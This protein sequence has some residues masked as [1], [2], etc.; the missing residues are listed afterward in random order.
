[1]ISR[2]E[3]SQIKQLWSLHAQYERW[4]FLENSWILHI[5]KASIAAGVFKKEDYSDI[6]HDNRWVVSAIGSLVVS[7]IQSVEEIT[8]HDVGA[9]L[10][11]YEQALPPKVRNLLHFGLTSSDLVDTGMAIAINRS[12]RVVSDGLQGLVATLQRFEA[13]VLKDWEVIPLVNEY[14]HGQPAEGTLLSTIFSRWKKQVMH[15]WISSPQKYFKWGGPLDNNFSSVHDKLLLRILMTA[16]RGMHNEIR[17]EHMISADAFATQTV[18]RQRLAATMFG[19]WKVS[20]VLAKIAQDLRHWHLRGF[21][22]ASEDSSSSAMA[23]KK[24]PA[25]LEKVQGLE[26][27]LQGFVVVQMSNALLWENRDI[28]HSS[29]DRIT[30]PDAFNVVVH[31]IATLSAYLSSASLDVA[32]MQT[33]QGVG[34]NEQM[35]QLQLEGKEYTQAWKLCR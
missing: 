27:V 24:N 12:A 4:A 5:L 22:R 13:R 34:K 7:E 28:S 19:L 25:A 1:M 20:N 35:I 26:R 30:I 33:N 2:Y 16:K 21:V 6:L 23:G 29:T 3:S 32:V 8:H 17:Q 14:T 18:S 11:V 31:Q 9:F 10:G 15:V